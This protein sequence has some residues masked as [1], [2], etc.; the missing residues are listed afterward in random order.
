MYVSSDHRL[1]SPELIAGSNKRVNSSTAQLNGSDC[2]I[3]CNVAS[4]NQNHYRIKN[5]FV[6]RRRR[7]SFAANWAKAFTKSSSVANGGAYSFTNNHSFLADT[8]VL[9]LSSELL[10]VLAIALFHVLTRVSCVRSEA[11]QIRWRAHLLDR[12]P[13]ILA[14]SRAI[15]S[16]GR[17]LPAGQRRMQHRHRVDSI[18]R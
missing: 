8:I 2:H 11:T 3:A 12:R 18:G 16:V 15:P 14:K 6:I 1:H 13:S 5:H 9:Q 4:D 7:S 10:S 17:T